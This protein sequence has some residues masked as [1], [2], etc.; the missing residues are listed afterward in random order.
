VI[1][2]AAAILLGLVLAG[3]AAAAEPRNIYPPRLYGEFVAGRRVT[4]DPGRW[5]GVTTLR[6][7]WMRCSR[8][9]SICKP[10]PDLGSDTTLTVRPKS[11]P[12]ADVGAR[13]KVGIMAFGAPGMV[14]TPLS[15]VITAAGRPKLS[16][17]GG[18]DAYTRPRVGQL[19]YPFFNW[20]GAPRSVTYRWQRCGVTRC[21]DIPGATRIRYRV[22]HADVGR[23]LRIVST[24]RG[25]SGAASAS[26]TTKPVA[27]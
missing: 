27:G 9:G 16:A 5:S 4:L 17:K 19:L 11:N 12:G 22:Q 15:P 10:A 20:E 23:R 24:A 21:D 8:D 2:A 7:V 26:L 6:F 14:W 13:L 25:G 18:I 3:G 1:R